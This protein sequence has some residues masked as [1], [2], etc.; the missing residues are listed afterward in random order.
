MNWVLIDEWEQLCVVNCKFSM[1][2]VVCMWKQIGILMISPRRAALAWAKIPEIQPCCCARSRIGELVS[3]EWESLSSRRNSLAW[4]RIRS[5]FEVALCLKSRPGESG[6]PK[7]DNSLAQARSSS[8]SEIQCRIG[9]L[10]YFRLKE[11]MLVELMW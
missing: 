11:A 8:L 6:S 4:A 10:L 2:C 7:R 5:N 9:F 1:N 3:L